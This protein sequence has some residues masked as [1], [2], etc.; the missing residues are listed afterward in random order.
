MTR[1]ADSNPSSAFVQDVMR[2]P[3]VA[4]S[5]PVLKW[6][7]TSCAPD[8]RTLNFDGSAPEPIMLDM[9][10]VPPLIVLPD[11]SR[12]PSGSYRFKIEV[13]D[14]TGN[15]DSYDLIVTV[16]GLPDLLPSS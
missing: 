1:A 5:A 15:D 10:S 16:V 2:T 9:G 4:D 7:I 11:L 12:V 8:H 3:Q 13:E 14:Q 6:R